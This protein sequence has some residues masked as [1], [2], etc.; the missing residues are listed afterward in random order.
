MSIEPTMNSVVPAG[1]G[2]K[3]Q[4][5]ADVDPQAL[6]EDLKGQDHVPSSPFDNLSRLET[7][8]KFWKVSALFLFSNSNLDTFGHRMDRPT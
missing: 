1:H 2:E 6:G 8:R 4:V 7:L 3:D 5:P